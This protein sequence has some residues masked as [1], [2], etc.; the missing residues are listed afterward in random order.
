[1][2]EVLTESL[3]AYA[4]L[5]WFGQSSI[6]KTCQSLLREKGRDRTLKPISRR[7]KYCTHGFHF[8]VCGRVGGFK[9]LTSIFFFPLQSSYPRAQIPVTFHIEQTCVSSS[10]AL[11]QYAGQWS[12]D[13]L[14]STHC[15]GEHNGVALTELRET[16]HQCP[17][18]SPSLF[19]PTHTL[20]SSILSLFLLSSSSLS[21]S[22]SSLGLREWMALSDL[23][24]TDVCSST[25]LY[26]QHA[27]LLACRSV[28][29][30]SL[31]F[32][33]SYTVSEHKEQGHP[34]LSPSVDRQRSAE[35]RH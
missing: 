11:F 23:D 27:C 1:M 9:N 12:D 24:D 15:T 16:V 8:T 31:S 22:L 18:P 6:N 19:F 26:L 32:S 14:V 30:L 10:L 28:H 21:P 2:S 34:S 29:S 7:L 3:H 5:T 35:L 25:L 13:R 4:N 17:P 20:L 33:L